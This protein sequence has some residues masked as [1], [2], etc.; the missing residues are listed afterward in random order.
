[1]NRE[2]SPITIRSS[3]VLIRSAG[4]KATGVP[5][6]LTSTMK[7]VI[8]ACEAKPIKASVRIPLT[9][10]DARA[11]RI[12]YCLSRKRPPH[13]WKNA[14]S[15][16]IRD[17]TVP[18]LAPS[19]GLPDLR[20]GDLNSGGQSLAKT[21]ESG[22]CRKRIGELRGDLD[23][24]PGV[25]DGTPEDRQRQPEAL[26]RRVRHD[27]HDPPSGDRLAH[28][29]QEVLHEDLNPDPDAGDEIVFSE[30]RRQ[31]ER[32]EAEKEARP[33]HDEIALDKGFDQ[34]GGDQG[35]TDHDPETREINEDRRRNRGETAPEPQL[36][37]HVQEDRSQQDS[38]VE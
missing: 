20:I 33:R 24:Q 8:F 31:P 34:P 28:G 1:M 13:S 27:R 21:Q 3:I 4:P 2:T 12:Q 22:R 5:W 25:D 11:A 36:L 16:A 17:S 7:G 37:H 14:C 19:R 26:V 30:R 18:A 35:E 38:A 10:S 32:S 6:R 9:A 15:P 23:D 29:D